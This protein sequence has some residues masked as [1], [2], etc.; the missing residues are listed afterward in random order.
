MV[1]NSCQILSRI[2]WTSQAFCLL[3]ATLCCKSARLSVI[4]LLALLSF[5]HSRFSLSTFYFPFFSVF[6][7]SWLKAN[8]SHDCSLPLSPPRFTC[9]CSLGVPCLCIFANVSQGVATCPLTN[10]TSSSS[11]VQFFSYRVEWVIRH[12]SGQIRLQTSLCRGLIPCQ[13]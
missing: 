11:M 10:Y 9:C 12:L 4:L 2:A 1:L 7:L 6:Y 3:H 8:L 5:L 13:I